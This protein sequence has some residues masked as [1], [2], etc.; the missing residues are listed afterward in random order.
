MRSAGSL[1]ATTVVHRLTGLGR[2]P[3]VP[4]GH[5]PAD[6]V[7]GADPVGRVAARAAAAGATPLA[8]TAL[9]DLWP[10]LTPQERREVERP[11]GDGRPGPVRIA[12]VAV[13]QVDGTTCGS[14]VL[15]VLAAGGDPT[16]ALWLV[17]GR[18]LPGHL[19]PE[20][21]PVP[22]AD[23]LAADPAVRLTALQRSVKRASTRRALGP[24]PWPA[25]LGTPPWTAARTA[26]FPG[27]RWTHTLVDDTDTALVAS[28]LDR[29]GA[30]LAA[31][32][33]VP[34]FTGGDLGRGVTAAVPRHVVLLLP[35]RGGTGGDLALYEPGQGR[36]HRLARDTLAQPGGPHPALGGWSHVCWAVLPR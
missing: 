4:R 36:V 28:V 26:R 20:L 34:L 16:L 9:V 13:R 2:V 10:R 14:A 22:A 12:G 25:A 17:T 29:A 18:L 19:P 15:A 6:A 3:P 8:V 30:A 27:V 33:P 24:L 5:L 32:V 23:L 35:G 1:Q 31:G 21:A 11:L 7:A